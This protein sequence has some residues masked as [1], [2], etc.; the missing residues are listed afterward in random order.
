MRYTLSMYLRLISIQIRSQMQYRGSFT[1]D[2]LSTAMFSGVYFLAIAL[3]LQRFGHIAGWT[4]GEVAFLFG[5]M[6]MSFTTMDLIF[7]GFDP[8]WFSQQV[9]FGRFDQILLRPLNVNV[10]ILGSAFLIRRFG[11]IIQGLGIFLFSLTLTD[12]HWTLAK[13]LYLPVVYISMVIA[14][15]ALFIIG[16]A[17]IFWTVQ[18]IEALNILTY[19][20]NEMMSYPMSIYP[21]WLRRIF[22]F[23]I[24]FIFLNYYPALYFLDKPDPLNFPPFAPFISPFAAAAMLFGALAF[25]RYGLKHYQSTGS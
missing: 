21:G 7:S 24:P 11:R 4:L 2:L 9:R 19:G 10:Q 6:E 14:F 17:L 1:M 20:G 3:V 22:T 25:W 13:V 15:G 12:I 8:D 16:A 18:P 5:M 23:A